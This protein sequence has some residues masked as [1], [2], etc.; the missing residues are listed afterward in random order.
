VIAAIRSEWIK[1]RSARSNLVLLSLA[2]VLPIALTVL[3]CALPSK[4]DLNQTEDIFSLVLAGAAIGVTLF[5][6]LGV[7]VIGQEYRHST[8]R[9]TFTAEPNRVRVMLAKVITLLVTG[10][11]VGA[12]ATGVSYVIGHAILT[13]R[14][15]DLALAGSTQA[16]AVVGA[17]L[18]FALYALCGLGLGAIIRA[19]AGAITLLVV[20]P[21]IV[22]NIVGALLSGTKKWLPFNAGSALTNTDPTRTDLLSPW[23][24]GALF[25]G[26]VTLLVVIGTVVV[27]RRDA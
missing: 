11:I 19:P 16:R 15:F 17:V 13:G 12:I 26:F 20:W 1:L 4:S 5:G 14:G 10:L 3:V 18:L 27:L 24:G 9:V 22:E 2:V 8:I 23:A 25:A 21:L 6:V 7:L